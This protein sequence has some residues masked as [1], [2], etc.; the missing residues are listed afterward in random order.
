MEAPTAGPEAET[1]FHGTLVRSEPVR[2][3][4]LVVPG[5]WCPVSPG[6][7]DTNTA[8]LA[9]RALWSPHARPRGV[10]YV[11]LIPLL[12]CLMAALSSGARDTTRIR[13]VR[14]LGRLG[15]VAIG[16]AMVNTTLLANYRVSPSVGIILALLAGV[17][18]LQLLRAEDD[19]TPA[20]AV[21]V[22]SLVLT[23]GLIL[24]ALSLGS[25]TPT[26]TLSPLLERLDEPTRQA[27][28]EAPA[29]L[30]A[31]A[32]HLSLVFDTAALTAFGSLAVLL[33]FLKRRDGLATSVLLATVAADLAYHAWW[34]AG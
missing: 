29:A 10:M 23:A 8:G 27:Y 13:F 16:V 3:L 17:G 22:A 7:T 25:D 15:L 11:G 26:E 19:V 30:A 32:T 4:E 9:A 2:S 14:W 21:A 20:M 18:L 5:I 31:N 6:T 34:L 1:F 33:W 28:A 12:L 24:V